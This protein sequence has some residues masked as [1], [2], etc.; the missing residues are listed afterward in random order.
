LE[1][2]LDRF[3]RALFLFLSTSSP[4]D[5]HYTNIFLW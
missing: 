5:A 4:S 1:E 2:I 3:P